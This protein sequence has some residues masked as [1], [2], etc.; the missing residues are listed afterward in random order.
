[1]KKV[2]AAFMAIVVLI[3]GLAVGVA[4]NAS[5]LREKER[6][7]ASDVQLALASQG[8]IARP[9]S[10]EYREWVV[11]DV[12]PTV[13]KVDEWEIFVYVFD[14]A[15]EAEKYV[16]PIGYNRG[17]PQWFV[18]IGSWRNLHICCRQSFDPKWLNYDQLSQKEKE[19]FRDT[20][21]QQGKLIDQ[22]QQALLPVFN[23]VQVKTHQIETEQMIYTVEQKSYS[24]M[25]HYG[26][27][28]LYDNWLSWELLSLQCKEPPEA[29][30]LPVQIISDFK[31]I[32]R[33]YVLTSDHIWDGQGTLEERDVTYNDQQFF[34]WDQPG[35]VTFT[36]T[37]ER[38]DLHD[39]A[40]LTVDLGE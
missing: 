27:G 18:T 24:S 39:E 8:F 10:G 14:D 15:L 20:Y 13:Y 30:R 40:T 25:M 12:M 37:F 9:M 4:V 17:D 28:L 11:R 2:I 38:G 36:I 3:L 31:S 34:T 19:R 32:G 6:L 29:E 16:A 7:D 22:L 21:Y 5:H 26:K 35:Q 1:M 23:D 33:R